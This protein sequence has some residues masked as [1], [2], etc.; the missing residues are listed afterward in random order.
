MRGRPMRARWKRADRMS[1]GG[2]LII[3]LGHS[4]VVHQHQTWNLEIPDA[5]LRI[6]PE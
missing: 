1:W 5:M 3:V 2:N 4:G 6:A